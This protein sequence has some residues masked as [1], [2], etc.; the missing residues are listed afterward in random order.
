MTE[1]KPRNLMSFKAAQEKGCFK[2]DKL[3][4]LIS[5]GKI[6][7]YK[8]GLYTL[9]DADSL[10]AYQDALPRVKPGKK[11][12]GKTPAIVATDEVKS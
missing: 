1:T 5:E 6:I 2:K 11:M 9:I 7:A 8:D 3:Y 12:A 10:A 4:R